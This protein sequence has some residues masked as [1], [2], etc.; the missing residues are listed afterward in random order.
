MQAEK[1]R[2]IIEVVRNLP[3]VTKVRVHG[4]NKLKDVVF[5]DDILFYYD[6]GILDQ[7]FIITAEVDG[8]SLAGFIAGD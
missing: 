2:A 5:D 8:E 1:T 4:A 3:F 6:T 7:E